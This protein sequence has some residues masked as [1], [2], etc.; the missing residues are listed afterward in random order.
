MCAHNDF[1]NPNCRRPWEASSVFDS[2]RRRTACK[3][4]ESTPSVA[5]DRRRM[6][7]PPFISGTLEVSA[8]E[9]R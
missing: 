2:L 3:G 1:D 9:G 7:V 8:V 4:P 6:D 5:L